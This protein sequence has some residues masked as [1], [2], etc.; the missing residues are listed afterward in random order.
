MKKVGI[1]TLYY[2]TYNYGAQLQAY[3]LQQ[4]I[5]NLG[6]ECEQIRF[7]WSCEQTIENYSN[8]SIDQNAFYTFSKKIKHSKKI[9]NSSNISDCLNEYDA[10]VVG[11]DQVWGV[12]KS[13]PLINLSVMAL[14]FVPNNKLKVA[15]AA[16]F[17]ST[18]P[19]SVI[20]EILKLE[21]PKF[22]SLSMRE[23]TSSQY[24]ENITK[25]KVESVLDP[26][27]LISREAWDNVDSDSI[28]ENEEYVFYYTAGADT[29][30]EKI[31]SQIQE[32]YHLL[33]KRLG[34]ISGEQVGPKE[35]IALVKNAKYVI[36]D[37]FHA[38]VFSI[39]YNKNFVVLPVDIVPTD[40][41][42]NARLRNLL[43]VFGLSERFVDYYDGNNACAE[44][45]IGLL[46]ENIVYDSVE[47]ILEH[48]RRKSL[49][50][51]IN[52][53]SEKNSRKRLGCG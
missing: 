8:A 4:T 11:S 22:D 52:A 16:S 15:Y 2:K 32:K 12:E 46:D 1:L 19:S 50:Y 17:G 30:Q 5:E 36:T 44:R 53:L 25:K 43:E 45:V 26:V 7:V 9:Y 34:Y 28:T 35:F 14:S 20:E 3:A 47:R 48:E 37:S 51:L 41:S 18:K 21:L 24:L 13:M 33:I 31:L 27:M 29:I 23:K 42:K 6:Y 39:I 38:T 49:D 10:F 40:R